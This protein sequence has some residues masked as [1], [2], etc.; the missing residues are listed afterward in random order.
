MTLE[1]IESIQ[2]VFEDD[3]VPGLEMHGG[4]GVI[5]RIEAIEDDIVVTIS[6]TGTCKECPS[7]STFTLHSIESILRAEC[8][9]AIVVEIEN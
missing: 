9:D 7:S 4:K 2:T 3:I 1:L 5:K 6:Y 8:S